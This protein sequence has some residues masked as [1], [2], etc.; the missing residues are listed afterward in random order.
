MDLNSH[1]V[2]KR[3]RFQVPY[4]RVNEPPKG[5]H[6][7]PAPDHSLYGGEARVVPVGHLAVVHE[8]LQLALRQHRVHEVELGKRVNRDLW[9]STCAYRDSMY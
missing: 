8:P 2:Q 9:Q 4:L 3:Y 5:S 6:G 7:D 1:A